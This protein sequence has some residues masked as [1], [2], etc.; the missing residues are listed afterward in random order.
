MK[1]IT[2]ILL[3]ALLVCGMSSA[4]YAQES[5]EQVDSAGIEV[6]AQADLPIV[7]IMPLEEEVAV[8]TVPIGTAQEALSLPETLAAIV[9]TPEAEGGTSATEIP[10]SWQSEPAYDGEIAGNY[11]FTPTPPEGYTL[12]EGVG[13]PQITVTVEEMLEEQSALETEP[14]AIEQ[15]MEVGTLS[16]GSPTE[17]GFGG[18][19]WHVIGCKGTGVASTA[20]TATLLAKGSFGNTK[21]DTADN[22]YDGSALKGEMD[23]AANAITGVEANLIVGRTLEG[24]SENQGAVGYNENKT[25]GANVD[26]AKF[27]PLSVG[28]ANTLSSEVLSYGSDWWLRSPG[29][30][31]NHAAVV[32]ADGSVG[33]GGIVVFLNNAIR[34]AF[35]LDLSSAIFT[36]AASN[37]SGKNLAAIGGG[38]VGATAPTGAIKLTATDN[39]NLNLD[40]ASVNKSAVTTGGTI[41]ITF[42]GAETGS[43]KYVS[44]VLQNSSGTVTH[45][46]KLS[47]QASGTVNLA[48]PAAPGNYTL[49][50]FNEQVNADNYTD[51]ASTPKDISIQVVSPPPSP[52][53]VGV[54]VSPETATV[55]KGKSQQ[56]AANVISV[57]GASTAVAWSVDGTAS[58]I[59]NTG[60]L[61]VAVGEEKEELTVTAISTFDTSKK[62]TATVTVTVDVLGVRWGQARVDLTPGSTA[63]VPATVYMDDGAGGVFTGKPEFVSNNPDVATVDADGKITATKTLGKVAKKA[64]IVASSKDD[65]AK[66]AQLII[67]VKPKAVPCSSVRIYQYP[68]GQQLTVGQA[69]RIR[70][71]VNQSGQWGTNKVRT[72]QS[73]QPDVLSVD[74]TGRV[75]GLK[76]GQS[77]VLVF[78]DG[79]VK[80]NVILTVK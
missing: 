21:F 1:K 70:A 58:T 37:A 61:T 35:I 34:P 66:K 74:S 60:K 6:Q 57:G 5:A 22:A 78:A 63:K 12:L 53:I 48:I 73:S 7:E 55:A 20:T 24:G 77:M 64:V 28:E 16:V 56:F 18:K 62:A 49:R 51:F 39:V 45:Y 43:G 44:C 13:L 33:P 32:Y 59:D 50:V 30:L 26:N 72:Y 47:D 42:D 80:A 31:N 36:S 15:S 17:M 75:V 19:E 69:G 76:P 9:E 27:W 40:S 71:R 11:V 14:Q 23:N 65:P 3:A 29:F 25:K 8:Q 46:G 67:W 54:E 79:K 4:V 68:A 41:A 38:L 2:A 10:V 52:A